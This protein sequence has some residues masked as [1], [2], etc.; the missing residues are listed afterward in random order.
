M[1]PGVAYSLLLVFRL[2]ILVDSTFAL[3]FEFSTIQQCGTVAIKFVGKNLYLGHS[4]PTSLS[5]V[6][7]HDTALTYFFPNFSIISTGVNLNFL[8]Y[9][10]GSK[11]LAS[12]D[13]D[14]G[15]SL[16]EVSDLIHILPS[17][18][19]SRSCLPPPLVKKKYF[20]VISPLSQ[21]QTFTVSY[22]KSLFSEAPTIRLYE[23]KGYSFVLRL[24]SDQQNSGIATYMM[25]FPQGRTILLLMGD[26]KNN[27]S[28]SS[29]LF[30]S[31][32]C[33]KYLSSIFAHCDQ[34]TET[35]TATHLV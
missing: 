12:L 6:P 27:I 4:I 32:F 21:C 9:S 20:E 14:T 28:E 13:D 30:L 19:D 10:S 26:S 17:N 29:P 22:N 23:P 31:M 25:A 11:F 33:L 3:R 15:K 8:P 35:Q 34:S 18:T 1:W 2:S 24:V 7:V 5:I 16:I